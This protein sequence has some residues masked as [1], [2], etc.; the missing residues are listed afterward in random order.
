VTEYLDLED[1]LAAA[2]GALGHPADVRDIGLLQAS[3]A[4]PQ[5]TVFGEDAYPGLD[6]KA[7]AL[8]HSIVTGHPLVDGNRRLGWVAVRVFY[9]LNEVDVHPPE[10]DAYDLVAKV[11]DGS[12]RDVSA[13]ATTFRTWRR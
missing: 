11:A 8:L 12:L 9:L 1:L 10:N 13:I 2:E 6:E 7:A 3:A 4:R 5:A